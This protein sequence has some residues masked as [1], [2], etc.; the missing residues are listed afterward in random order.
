MREMRERL[1]ALSSAAKA[2]A[3]SIF[4]GDSLLE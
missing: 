4:I 3:P 1:R 2:A